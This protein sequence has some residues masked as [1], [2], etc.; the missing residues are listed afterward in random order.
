MTQIRAVLFDF[1]GVLA[2]EGFGHGLE[3]MAREQRLAV[4]DMTAEGMRAVYDSGFVLGTGTE[5]DFWALM[6]RRT[7]LRG[8]DAELTERILRGF[9][10]R[11]WMLELVERLRAQGYIVGILSDQTDWLDRLDARYHF[12]RLFNP[13]Y[14]SFY[15]GKGKRDP[16]LFTD[17]A[18]ALGLSPAAIL[19]IDDNPGNVARAE[20]RGQ[21]AILYRDREGFMHE[22]QTKLGSP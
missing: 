2:E 9:V 13:V 15:L 4:D 21:Q 5:A 20:A 3:A 16:S 11:P 22:L 12:Y 18:N 6:R 19:F 1:G 8:G 17:V 7:G 14:N 10:I